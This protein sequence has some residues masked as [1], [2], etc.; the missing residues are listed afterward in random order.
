MRFASYSSKTGI[1]LSAEYELSLEIDRVVQMLSCISF[2]TNTQSN[3]AHVIL[4]IM[5]AASPKQ[6]RNRKSKLFWVLAIAL[7]LFLLIGGVWF[8]DYTYDRN[9]DAQEDVKY[10]RIETFIDV[11][12]LRLERE[13]PEG[14]WEISKYC[15]APNTKSSFNEYACGIWLKSDI[16]S[17][18][19]TEIVNIAK[20]YSTK[21]LYVSKDK[22]T[23]GIYYPYIEGGCSLYF[24]ELTSYK[25]AFTCRSGSRAIRYPLIDR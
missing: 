8:Y 4:R 20:E 16:S 17:N 10:A 11:V 14:R 5:K 21:E 19:K 6:T 9:V 25:A 15:D 22:E 23:Y 2:F 3:I 12:K 18:D 13:V 7:P 24:T 1:Y